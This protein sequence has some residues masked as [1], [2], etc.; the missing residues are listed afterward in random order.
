[1]R[2]FGRMTSPCVSYAC[3]GQ[4]TIPIVVSNTAVTNRHFTGQSSPHK[5]RGRQMTDE[6]LPSA[7]AR[8]RVV[9]M[10]S[11]RAAGFGLGGRNAALNSTPKMPFANAS[12]VASDEIA[13]CG[14]DCAVRERETAR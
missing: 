13:D 3:D 6:D 9:H 2:P 12:S 11:R 4:A 7:N 8:E 10:A 14:R 5:L 1:M